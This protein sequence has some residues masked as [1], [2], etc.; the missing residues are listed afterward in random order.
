[1]MT[2][3]EP[4]AGQNLPAGC[5]DVPD[6]SMGDTCGEC[7]YAVYFGDSHVACS[8]EVGAELG[9]MSVFPQT[10]LLIA[11]DLLKP[12]TTEACGQFEAG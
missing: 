10:V 11:A 3:Y 7:A 6:T 8:L 12:D 1:M 5:Y 9:G 4:G 2:D